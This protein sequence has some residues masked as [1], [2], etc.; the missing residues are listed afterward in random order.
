MRQV[1][2]T[3]AD[4]V[5]GATIATSKACTLANQTKDSVMHPPHPTHI[6]EWRGG[7]NLFI[8]KVI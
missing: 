2:A 6:V 4:M 8:F 7:G 3:R 1:P 5:A